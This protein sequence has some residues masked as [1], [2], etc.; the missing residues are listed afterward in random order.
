MTRS[1]ALKRLS[2]TGSIRSAKEESKT[3]INPES[4]EE[5][6]FH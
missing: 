6:I 3:S 2:F 5:E 1:G 4:N